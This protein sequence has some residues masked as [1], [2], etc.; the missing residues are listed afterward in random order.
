MREEGK[1]KERGNLILVLDEAPAREDSSSISAK[2]E[3]DLAQT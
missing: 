2:E 1:G 3:R